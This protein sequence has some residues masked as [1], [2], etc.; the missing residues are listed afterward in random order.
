M[1]GQR[2]VYLIGPMGSGK[3]AVGKRLA[4]LLG[5]EFFDSDA[6]IEKRTGVD[7][8]YIFEKEGETGFRERE[9]EVIDSLT[10]LQD[11]VIATGGGAVL[12]PENRERLA[13]RGRVVYLR[14]G[15]RQQLER[16]K[17]GRQ[18]P[19]LY[20]ADPETRLRELMEVRAPLYESIASVVVATD[21]RHVRIVADDI[22]DRLKSLTQ[23]I[24]ADET[25]VVGTKD[26]DRMATLPKQIGRGE[27]RFVLDGR[28]DDVRARR[29]GD[30]AQRQVA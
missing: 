25:F 26:G 15:I 7:V 19:L 28:D 18:R 6:E 1:R 10:Q 9:R 20:T 29:N 8:R 2:N 16:T 22:L 13:A 5:K 17:H 12:L 30:A 3:T 23:R 27:H 4:A 24:A 21:G 11:V 14:T